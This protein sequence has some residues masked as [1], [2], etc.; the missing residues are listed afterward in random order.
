[1]AETQALESPPQPQE[2][3]PKAARTVNRTPKQGG[4]GWLQQHCLG[5]GS[6]LTAWLQNIS[7]TLRQENEGQSILGNPSGDDVGLSLLTDS[8]GRGSSCSASTTTVNPNW[9]SGSVGWEARM[10]QAKRPNMPCATAAKHSAEWRRA[11]DILAYQPRA[12]SPFWLGEK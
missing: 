5:K 6:D 11:V 8:S 3:E 2:A 4:H 7:S 9:A 12:P 10:V 1:M